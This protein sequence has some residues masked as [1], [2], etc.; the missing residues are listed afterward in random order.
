MV[1]QQLARAKAAF[2]REEVRTTRT[3]VEN[4]ELHFIMYRFT[5]TWIDDRE[6]VHHGEKHSL[7]DSLSVIQP[8]EG[9]TYCGAWGW[10]NK[11]YAENVGR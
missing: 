2:C 10:K 9:Q 5:V 1:L 7:R 3:T 6:I 11:A 4:R 8:T